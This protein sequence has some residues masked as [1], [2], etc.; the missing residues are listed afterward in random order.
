M[1]NA[2]AQKPF[3]KISAKKQPIRNNDNAIKPQT[4]EPNNVN[5]NNVS[6]NMNYKINN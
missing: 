4:A 2:V 3:S 1:T 6:I 5:V